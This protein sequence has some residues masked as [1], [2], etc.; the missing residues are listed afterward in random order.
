M[1]TRASTASSRPAGSPSFAAASRAYSASS[2]PSG[3]PSS[4]A[5]ITASSAS[6]VVPFFF[7]AEDGI[8]GLTVT[9]VQTCALP[10]FVAAPGLLGGRAGKGVERV[11]DL[12]GQGCDI[13]FHGG[14]IL[15]KALIGGIVGQIFHRIA[16][17]GFAIAH[18]HRKLPNATSLQC[19]ERLAITEG[20]LI[21][22]QLRR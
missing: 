3:S 22:R 12:V 17:C 10:I 20:S 5:A 21:A 4:A 16:H 18:R 1:S 7:Q 8:R 13:V 15:L 14:Y 2:R 6:R 9:G 19:E 11:G